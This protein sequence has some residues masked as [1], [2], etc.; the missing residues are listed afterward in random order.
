MC[1]KAGKWHEWVKPEAPS[2]RRRREELVSPREESRSHFVERKAGGGGGGLGES[3]ICD[4]ISTPI[5]SS[6][7]SIIHQ[8]WTSRC[9]F[10][11]LTTK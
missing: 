2:G 1:A 5:N 8:H 3:E 4:Q 10:L 11:N 6:T 7:T 9:P